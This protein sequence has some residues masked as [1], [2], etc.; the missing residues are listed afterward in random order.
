MLEKKDKK[1]QESCNI[2]KVEYLDLSRSRIS[3][4]KNYLIFFCLAENEILKLPPLGQW[5]CDKSRDDNYLD[6]TKY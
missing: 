5:V 6:V 2:L 1:Q 3:V 4:L